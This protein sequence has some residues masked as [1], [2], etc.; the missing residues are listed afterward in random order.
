MPEKF[1]IVIAGP[2]AIGKTK[3]SIKLAKHLNTAIINADSRQVYKELNIGTA[4]PSLSELSEAKHFLVDFL[5]L[6]I[7]YNAGQFE[8]DA[9]QILDFLF[10]TKNM[11]IVSGGS[12]LYI[13]ALC[14]GMDDI[15]QVPG[16]FREDLN[17]F[18]AQHGITPLLKELTEKDPEYFEYVDKSNTNRVIR[19]LEIIRGT[20][21]KFSSFRND[22][23]KTR[24]FTIIKIGLERNRE[25]LYELINQ[26][27]D[28]MIAKGLVN[29]AFSLK[30][31]KNCNALQ[32]VGYREIY[33]YF[34]GRY[35]WEEAVRLLKRNS[36]RYAK[37]Q[38]TWFKGDKEYQWFNPENFE[39]I[40]DFIR[41]KT[42]NN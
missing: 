1:L 21:K 36:R 9:L 12:G 11:V 20:G 16:H 2:T 10:K 13:K 41:R 35:N 5:P 37:R 33:D 18:Y 24:D 40:L 25:E 14:E 6:D 17:R 31:F 19:A 27:M 8:K 4:K 15:P 38:M 34:E 22:K 42:G 30:A 28:L 3:L 39:E 32:T 26:R 23:K 29:E 7:T